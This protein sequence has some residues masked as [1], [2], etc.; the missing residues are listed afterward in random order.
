MKRRILGA[1]YQID[2]K[3][4]GIYKLIFDIVTK[5]FDVVYK[6]EI[7]TPV[8]EE[9]EDCDIYSTATSW[10]SMQKSGD[11]FQILNYHVGRAKLVAFFSGLSHTSQYKTTIAP[12]S[13]NRYVC[14]SGTKPKSD[15]YFMIGG[16]YDIYIDAKTYVVS[17]ELVSADEDGYSAV[18]YENN[19]FI[20]LELAD[21]EVKYV[22]TY[23]YTAT[24]DI[25]GYGV[26]SDDMPRIFTASYQE[27]KLTATDES[28]TYLNTNRNGGYYFKKP[29]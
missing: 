8:Y 1:A 16:T 13:E 5:S 10:T 19:E 26:V 3:V 14:K 12:E 2:V 20:N 29:G 21:N 22:Y 25:G 11:K 17:V 18:V 4:S 6:A 24:S 7:T 28:M 9:I 27:Y 15:V 23:R